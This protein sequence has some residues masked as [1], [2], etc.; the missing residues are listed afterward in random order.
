[1]NDSKDSAPRISRH[2]TSAR[3]GTVDPRGRAGAPVL[4][5]PPSG[6][7]RN[8][9]RHRLAFWPNGWVPRID[10]AKRHQAAPERLGARR[11]R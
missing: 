6:I 11:I 9:S 3:G 8:D 1:M 4:G 7:G 2:R 10:R 5:R